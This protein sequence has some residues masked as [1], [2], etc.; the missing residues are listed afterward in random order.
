MK[1]RE[2]AQEGI[3]D[4][5]E[6]EK[7][8]QI[9][10]SLR[11]RL[12]MAYNT[13]HNFV[14]AKIDGY[15]AKKCFLS[16]SAASALLRAQARLFEEGYSIVVFDCYRPQKAVDHF[17]RWS[18]DESD[19]RTKE[20]YYPEIS[21]K[22]E[23][24]RLGYIARRSGHSRA[25]TVDIGLVKTSDQS[26]VDMGSPFDFFGEVSHTHSAQVPE[27]LRENRMKLLHAM[28]ASGFENYRKEWWHYTLKNEPFPD[29][30]FDFDVK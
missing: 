20:E 24:F 6:F 22:S 12:L 28:E 9:P 21:P 16:E 26:L 2:L 13:T 23:L 19:T 8:H 25:S 11:I 3:V 10:E 17:V 15:H 7:E 5:S 4:V 14:G 29:R 30:Y 27:N 18:K 1:Q